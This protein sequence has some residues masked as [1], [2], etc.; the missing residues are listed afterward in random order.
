VDVSGGVGG[1]EGGVGEEFGV[2]VGGVEE[3][4]VA[5]AEE[6]EVGEL[7]GAAGLPGLDVVAFAPVVG[8]VAAGEAAVAVAHHEGVVEGGGD[9]A[10]GGAV[11]QDGG[12]AVAEDAVEGGV[13]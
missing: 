1:L 8:A 11:V 3:V 4:V 5:A 12:A 7:G 13:A 9:G 2:P 6:D 10:G